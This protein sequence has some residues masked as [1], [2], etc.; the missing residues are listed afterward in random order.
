MKKFVTC[1]MLLIGLFLTAKAD[2]ITG[3]EMYYTLTSAAGGQYGYHIT[4]KLFM[5]CFSGRQLPN[6]AIFGIFD[7]ATGQRVRDISVQRDRQQE[8]NLA[9]ASPCI[10]NPP[11]VCYQIGYY[12]FDVSLPASQAG[13]VV[14]IQVVYRVNGI[15]NLSPGYGNIGAT[16]TGEIPGTSSLSGA[17]G[18]NSARFAGNDMV[19]ICANNSFT[20]DF[21]AV[22]NDGDILRY[23]FCNAY[24]GGAG[25]G[26]TNSSP[27]PPPYTSVPYG[28]NYGS[29]NP[30][31]GRVQID[32]Q[33]GIITGIAPSEGIYVVTV[34][35]EEIR[36]GVVIATQRKDLQI[37]ITACTIASASLPPDYMLCKTSRDINLVNL[38]TSP[39]INTYN[40]E[41]SNGAGNIIYSSTSSTVSYTF[42]DT[43]TYAIKLV[44]NRNQMC[45]DSITSLAR[46]YPGFVPSFTFSGICFNKP[47]QFT[48]ASTTVFGQ[49]DSWTWDFNDGLNNNSSTQRNPVHTYSSLGV[50][51]VRLI[52]TNTKGCRDTA[53]KP[54]TIVDK[55]P[56]TLAFRD[57]L[58]CTPDAV[59][60]RAAG[61]GL[62]SW[63]PGVN[64]VNGNTATPTVSPI[65][66]TVYTVNLDDNGCLNRDSVRVRVVDHVTLQA[67][68]DTIIC[69][70]DKIRMHLV[71]DGLKYAWTSGGQ[72]LNTT[73]PN[74]EVVTFN[75]TLYEVTASIGSC[76]QK[77]QVMVTAIPY[78][79]ANA[80]PDTTICFAT[81]AQ[82]SGT[83]DGNR[84]QWISS[85][86]LSNITTLHPI[87]RPPSTTAYILSAFDTRGCPKPGYDTVIVNVLPD[88]NAYAGKDTSVV[89]NQPLQLM[90]TGGVRYQ[91]FPA[92]G[93]SNARIANPVITYHEPSSGILYKVLVYNE[94]GCIDSAF[95]RVKVYQAT[96]TVFVPNAFTPNGDGK[97]DVIRPLAAG[98]AKIDYFQIYNRWGQLVFTTTTNEHGWDGNIAG[99]QQNAGAYVW[100]VKGTD[101][102]GSP[103]IQRG[104][105]VL[106]R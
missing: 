96:P 88:I 34:C 76:S 48:D 99:K 68:N 70:G 1:G 71:S 49:L 47:T 87:A 37:R 39:L 15:A 40:W 30:L 63:T 100:V 29:G 43:G 54:V 83:T 13:Y 44:I 27:A 84:F 85:P 2:H 16:Y 24:Q 57:T 74:P 60:L 6:P 81:F 17:P 67:M 97:N 86:S 50:K 38:S 20:Y 94:A 31:G 72:P 14:T 53:I 59:Q 56:I 73:L 12:E 103:Y 42:P 92:N 106:I 64:I 11:V 55:P 89:I 95:K 77:D 8:L 51:N 61:S 104:T 52:A 91:W 45:S 79:V 25:G 9:A 66:T 35:V 41:L 32:Q 36:Q 19:V 102:L 28:P 80:G 21:G 75:N 3:G 23:T 58:I 46:V 5:D 78:P 101:Y 69:Q 22:D 90:A 33:T 26:G 82:L 7:K 62:F 93:L 10:T 98:I 18:N 105:L 4:A 65:N